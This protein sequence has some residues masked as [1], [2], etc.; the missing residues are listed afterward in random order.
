VNGMKRPPRATPLDLNLAPMVDVMMCLL[1][2]FMLATKMVEQEHSRVDLPVAR[3]AEEAEQQSLSNRFVVNVRPAAGGDVGVV[4]YVLRERPMPI[5][6]VLEQLAAQQRLD[7]EVNCVVRADRGI[8]YRH[9][10][11]L[12]SGCA[13]L[14]VRRLTLAALRGEGG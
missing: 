9:V 12:L 1:I 10:E 5:E 4:E 13:E 6:R 8:A 14:G 2:F 7:P 3:A 11:A